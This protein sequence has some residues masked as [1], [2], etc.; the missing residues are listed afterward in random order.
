MKGLT[1]LNKKSKEQLI[2]L[3][4]LGSVFI[5]FVYLKMNPESNPEYVE[6]SSLDTQ[7]KV[8]EIRLSDSQ[9]GSSSDARE[10][11]DMS[12][13]CTTSR[14]AAK[15][16]RYALRTRQLVDHGLKFQTT[17]Q[18]A[19]FLIPGEYF[20]LYSESTHTSRFSN[21]VISPEGVIQSQTT[22]SSGDSVYYWKP[23]GSKKE[24][25][26]GPTPLTL[27]NGLAASK[28]RG[29]VFTIAQTNA[30]DRVYK[31]ESLTFAEDGLVEV[32]GSYVPLTSNGY[33]AVL[34]QYDG[35]SDF[36]EAT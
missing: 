17:P 11:F 31:V 9:G 23:G 28:F 3:L 21:G 32:A 14:H 4:L 29:C 35:G 18:A 12:N 30:S 20:R 8:H 16:G 10:T 6:L 7:T 36:D 27:V 15:F 25:V 13:F 1:M 24:E 22:V 26:K 19:M 33:L 2:S 5:F 34:D